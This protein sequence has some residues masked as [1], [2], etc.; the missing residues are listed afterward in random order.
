MTQGQAAPPWWFVATD[1]YRRVC[2]W[3]AA[4][5][6]ADDTPWT[7]LA[8]R[9]LLLYGARGCGKTELAR[10]ACR[11][12]GLSHQLVSC[13]NDILGRAPGEA[14]RLLCAA[15]QDARADVVILDEVEAVFAE[16]PT[17]GVLRGSAAEDA[18][19]V[20]AAESDY[21]VPLSD[22]ARARAAEAAL[23]ARA[24]DIRLRLQQTLASVLR[25]TSSSAPDGHRCLAI[26]T[27]GYRV[28]LCERAMQVPLP[29]WESRHAYLATLQQPTWLADATAGYSFADLRDAARRLARMCQRHGKIVE[30]AALLPHLEAPSVLRGSRVLWWRPSGARTPPRLYGETTRQH[31]AT[32][33]RLTAGLRDTDASASPAV[34]GVLLYG[35]SGNG[36][37][38]LAE[39]LAHPCNTAATG[40]IPAA[41]VL[42]V[43]AAEIVSAVVGEA[44]QAI[45]Q[46]F[47]LAHAL[48]ECVLFFD[49]L[50]A[51][52]PARTAD[53]ASGVHDRILSVVLQ[54]LD[55]FHSG[56]GRRSRILVVA[57]TE[58]RQRIDRAVL[59]PG[60]LELHL[61]VRAPGAA[62]RREALLD[63]VSAMQRAGVPTV[64]AAWAERMAQRTAGASMAAVLQQADQVLWGYLRSQRA[65]A[66]NAEQPEAR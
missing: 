47:E 1:E 45:H 49:H 14:E 41:N 27:A 25:W 36:K 23:M 6:R 58:V 55:G 61:E 42:C 59:R 29:R 66:T 56:R 19:M 21:D 8:D 15:V 63:R 30:P 53:R 4:S 28:P 2:E 3:L 7:T 35:P 38:I 32:L 16:A 48:R 13:A 39:A 62:A 43:D 11:A 24:D 18:A 9:C 57:A 52:V 12:R 44:E 51:L 40:A 31:Y 5:G 26:A 17:G 60:R 10:Q 37:S 64:D 50:E 22:E 54:A 46:V 34:F 20:D 65:R 33:C